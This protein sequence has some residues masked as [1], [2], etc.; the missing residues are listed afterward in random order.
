MVSGAG[1]HGYSQHPRRN[2][3]EGHL[4]DPNEQNT[5]QSPGFGRN[6]ARQRLH[7]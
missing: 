2:W 6:N 5:Q 3:T 1:S 7:S 4:A